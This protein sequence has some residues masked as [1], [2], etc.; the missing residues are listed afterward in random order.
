MRFQQNQLI[1]D[2]IKLN[3]I[4]HFYSILFDRNNTWIKDFANIDRVFLL[5]YS[6]ASG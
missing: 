5:N 1:N 3:G 2:L 6:W 4:N